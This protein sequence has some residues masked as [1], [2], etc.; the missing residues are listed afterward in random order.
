MKK[1]KI[2]STN[3]HCT[4]VIHRMES[5][6]QRTLSGLPSFLYFRCFNFERTGGRSSFLS[7][8]FQSV[9]YRQTIF[10]SAPTVFVIYLNLIIGRNPFFYYYISSIS[11]RFVFGIT[12]TSLG[13][14]KGL[15]YHLPSLTNPS[16]TYLMTGWVFRGSCRVTKYFLSRESSCL[17]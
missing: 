3:H 4:H 8:F 14:G 13:R 6:M 9:P 15:G 2:T 1:K 5:W 7:H 17:Q 11:V 10:F 16:L 12:Q